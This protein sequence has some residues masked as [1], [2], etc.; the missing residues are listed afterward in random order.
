M[1]IT[2]TDCHLVGMTVLH[3]PRVIYLESMARRSA[4]C[5]VNPFDP[6]KLRRGVYTSAKLVRLENARLEEQGTSNDLPES[7]R[8]PNLVIPMNDIDSRHNF[9][10]PRKCLTT[11]KQVVDRYCWIPADA[12]A[13]GACEVSNQPYQAFEGL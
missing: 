8:G 4:P 9:P 12:L 2:T 5:V 7:V 13:L 3:I 1:L 11:A 10:K 6:L